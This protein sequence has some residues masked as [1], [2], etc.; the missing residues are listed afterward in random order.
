MTEDDSQF[1]KRLAVPAPRLCPHCRQ[2]RRLTHYNERA[3]YRNTCAACSKNVISIFAPDSP[4]T[5]FCSSCWWSD[6]N[7]TLQYGQEYVPGQSFFE[8]LYQLRH[9]V[10]QL[11]LVNDNEVRSTNCQYTNNFASGKN[12]YCVYCTWHNEDC[13]YSSYI[14]KSRSCCDCT[15]CIDS[16]LLYECVDCRSCYSCVGVHASMQSRDCCFSYDLRNCS[17]CTY[18]YGLRNQQYCYNNE[19]LSK[20]EYTDR[21]VELGLETR[22]GYS[23]ALHR[24]EQLITEAPRRFMSETGSTDCSGHMLEY[25]KNVRSSFDVINSQDCRYLYVVGPDGRDCYDVTCSGQMELC[26][27]SLS[28]DDCYRARF[29]GFTW[30]SNHVTYCFDCHSCSNLFGCAALRRNE[31]CILNKQYSKE[32]YTALV[33]LIEEEMRMSGEWGQFFPGRF[34]LFGYNE[35]AAQVF[36]PLAEKAAVDSGFRWYAAEAD[37]VAVRGPN[38]VPEVISE[39]GD[40]ICETAFGCSGCGKAYKL[41][42]QELEFYRKLKI[43]LSELCQNCRHGRRLAFRNPLQLWERPCSQCATEVLS[44]YAPDCVAEVVL[45]DECY[46]AYLTRDH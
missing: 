30:K 9:R 8:Q 20:E 10:P 39:V 6:A 21:M 44:S 46:P 17:N 4:S 27:D 19:Q 25:C 14:D 22:S 13:L 36:Q 28:V 11:A 40:E 29:C 1:H 26:Y 45:C 38:T 5:V 42:L 35:S 18:C 43:A 32:D 16:E 31:Y 24:F 34:S 15:F 3:L 23:S 12:C 41:V 2:Q 37:T 7:D 33:K